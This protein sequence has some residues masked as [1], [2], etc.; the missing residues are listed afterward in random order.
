MLDSDH[1]EQLS[2]ACPNLQR[3]DL[4]GN[5]ICL[6]NLQGLRSLASNCKNFQGLNLHQIRDSYGCNH[7]QLWEVLCTMHLTELAIEAWMINLCEPVQQQKLINIF[8]KYSS[9]QVLEVNC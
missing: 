3:L 6:S 9:L 7:L 8:Q 2:I 4:C 1:L 5:L